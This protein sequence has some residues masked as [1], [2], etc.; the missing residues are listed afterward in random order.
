MQTM[1]TLSS[2]RSRRT[3]RASPTYRVKSGSSMYGSLL[4][5]HL[6]PVFGVMAVAAEQNDVGWIES[7]I[8]VGRPR[9]DVVHV[10][11]RPRFAVA[12]A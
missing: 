9:L 12:A 6:L 4:M 10:K 8:G 3:P 1:W 7:K 2:D 11:R 5:A